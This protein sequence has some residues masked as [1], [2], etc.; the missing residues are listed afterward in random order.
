[1]LLVWDGLEVRMPDMMEVAVLDKGFVRFRGPQALS[2]DLRFGVEQRTF[3]PQR[4]GRRILRAAGLPT[5]SLEPCRQKWAGLIQG[6][7]YTSS[8]R[9]YLLRFPASQGIVAVLFSVQPPAD[10]AREI[11]STLGWTAPGHWRSWR[12]YDI[13]FETPP[14]HGLV[15]AVFQP[16]RYRI[17][18]AANRSTLLFDRLVPADILLD[19]APLSAWSQQYAEQNLSPGI[20]V[21]PQ[22]EARVD[23][24]RKSSF[25][26]PILP[27]FPGLT[28]PLRGCVRHALSDN[29]ILVVV[30]QGP[31][32]P[33]ELIRRIYHSYAIAPSLQT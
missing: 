25:L 21:I 20:Q 19:A 12:C 16:G 27:W 24:V 31:L 22:D 15:K 5:D 23:L 11:L 1:M 30:E 3:R 2:V 28:S 7:L 29:K 4:D 13:T 9:L 8:K 10:M 17:F 33:N 14:G 32:L 26:Y 6:D 18:L